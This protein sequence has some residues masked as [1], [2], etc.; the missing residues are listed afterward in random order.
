MPN[1]MFEIRTQ[2][3]DPIAVGSSKIVLRSRAIQIR[4]PFGGLVWNRPLSVSVETADG[5]EIEAPVQDVTR[6]VLWALLAL[7][8]VS[9]LLISSARAKK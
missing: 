3:S 9:A 7:T 6:M 8:V 4:L 5:R 2:V 1:S